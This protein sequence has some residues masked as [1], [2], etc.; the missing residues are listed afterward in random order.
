MSEIAAAAAATALHQWFDGVA[1]LIL[2]AESEVAPAGP[3]RDAVVLNILTRNARQLREIDIDRKGALYTPLCFLLATACHR[4][5]IKLGEGHWESAIAHVI[6]LNRQL[7]TLRNASAG[8]GLEIANPVRLFK[9]QMDEALLNAG[10]A[11][12]P[13]FLDAE[14][15]RIA[16]GLAINWGIRLLCAYALESEV[17]VEPTRRDLGW[18]RELLTRAMQWHGSSIQSG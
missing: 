15:R 6:S 13:T 11:G 17:P 16:L 10:V 3:H 18:I 9:E 1:N 8:V 5:G 4:L 12:V 7:G 14:G 2:K